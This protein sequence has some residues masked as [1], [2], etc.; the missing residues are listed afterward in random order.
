MTGYARS[1]AR[2][3]R[4]EHDYGRSVVPTKV[5]ALN[6]AS[7]TPLAHNSAVHHFPWT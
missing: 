3:D 7:I 4:D 1:L 5:S 2:V 6:P